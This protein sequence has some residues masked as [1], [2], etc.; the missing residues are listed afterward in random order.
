MNDRTF[1]IDFFELSFLVEA[2][3]PPVPIARAFFWQKTIDEHYFKLTKEERS[4]LLIWFKRNGHFEKGIKENNED[5][6]L[7]EARF[8]QENQYKIFVDF[9]TK[10]QEFE[11]FLFNDNYYTRS[12]SFISKEYITKIEKI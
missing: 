4:E 8:N 2:C 3:I 12:N 11:A 10:T 9:D 1:E 7:F 5:C 6:L